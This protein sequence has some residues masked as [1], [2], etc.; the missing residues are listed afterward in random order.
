MS[1]QDYYKLSFASR[2]LWDYLLFFS[3]FCEVNTLSM[4]FIWLLGFTALY[5]NGRYNDKILFLV[6]LL[7]YAFIVLNALIIFNPFFFK[8][9]CWLFGKDNVDNTFGE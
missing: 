3:R 5:L 1:K 2:R 4:F 7:G 8:F 6:L 9:A